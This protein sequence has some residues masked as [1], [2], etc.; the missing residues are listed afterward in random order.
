MIYT[1]GVYNFQ[2]L[3]IPYLYGELVGAISRHLIR[4]E[5][6]I[7]LGNIMPAGLLFSL[8]CLMANKP[9]SGYTFHN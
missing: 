7:K 9:T 5:T 1:L 4:Q 3:E 2:S 8:S 6:F